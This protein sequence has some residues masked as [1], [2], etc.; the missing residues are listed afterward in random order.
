MKQ[1]I[2]IEQRHLQE[3]YDINETAHTLS[4]IML[5]QKET[6]E[7]FEL[8]MK[9]KR[10]QFEK[11]MA[12]KKAL[13]DKKRI[14]TEVSYDEL[15]EKLEKK[16]K[17]EEEDYKYALEVSRRQETQEH[18]LKKEAL[19]KELA[20]KHK[21]IEE[22]E[23]LLST[24]LQ[25]FERL[26]EKVIQFPEELARECEKTAH[27]VTQKLE[28]QH[29]FVVALREKEIEGEKTSCFKKFLP[30]KTSLKSKLPWLIN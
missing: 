27:E 28:S 4:A 24:K 15:K 2:A 11:E 12:D 5:V 13:W 26:Q 21:I 19:E 14:D 8:E 17:R 30:W 1:A 7:K 6:Q 23:N 16:H 22:K 9:D 18:A 20:D 29:Q 10:E 3:L 25:K